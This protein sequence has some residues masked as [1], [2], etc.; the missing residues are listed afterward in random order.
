M[1]DS[2]VRVSFQTNTKANQRANFVLVG[3]A[4]NSSGVWP[5][6]RVGTALYTC[7][8]AGTRE[9]AEALGRLSTVLKHYSKDLDF[10]SISVAKKVALEEE[11]I[12]F[13]PK[14]KSKGKADTKS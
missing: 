14:S 9:V 7:H 11:T 2:I 13:L 3:H 5:Y 10:V 4:Q 12:S 8:D 1:V 6:E